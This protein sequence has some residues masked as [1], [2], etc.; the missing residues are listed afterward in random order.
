[1]A[2]LSTF[3][4]RKYFF[5]LGK[6]G[7]IRLM[8]LTALVG[9]SLGTAAMTVV[10]SAFAGLEELVSDQF[11]H[12]NPTLKLSPTDAPTWTFTPEDSAYLSELPARFDDLRILPVLKKRVLLT[13]G[14]NQHIAYLLGVD[15]GYATAHHLGDH[16]LTLADPGLDLGN[17]TLALG[18]GS[19]YY[20]GISS[21]NPPPVV[22]IY[23]PKISHETTALNLSE[24]L[25]TESA[26]VSSIHS[27]Q[28]DYD[29][30]YVIAPLSWAAPFLGH[31]SPSFYELHTDRYEQALRRD[32]QNHFGNR[33]RVETRLEQEAT[34]FRVMRSERLVVL[35]ILVFVVVL[36]SFGIVSALTII[37]LEKKSDIFTLWSMGASTGQLRGIFFKNGVLITLSGWFA[38]MVLGTSVILLQKHVGIITLGSGYVQEYYPVV[39]SAQQLL[40]TTA[41]VLGIGT[42]LSWWSTRKV[43][44]AF[45]AS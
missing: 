2:N 43:T 42:S 18:S 33:A 39:L 29:L 11:R 23:V 25:T 38:G 16:L 12:A 31:P 15:T 26:F 37:A 9:L 8:S 6:L 30:N 3:L 24:A 36:A 10:L 22:N 1:M 7:A 44:T 20:L 4:A 13:Y 19:A 21:T 40:T 28:P 41:I 5:S 32:L 17:Q 45:Q 14:E 27:I 35:A 34:L